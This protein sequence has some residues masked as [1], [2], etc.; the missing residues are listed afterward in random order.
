MDINQALSLTDAIRCIAP[1]SASEIILG[2]VTSTAP[3]AIEI[4]NDPKLVLNANTVVVPRALTDHRLE[5]E[6]VSEVT[7]SRTRQ[8]ILILN[9]LRVGNVLNILSFNQGKKYII[10]DRVS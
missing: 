8:E 1:T 4:I 5:V 10:L 9:A 6:F 3:L 2:V 7:G